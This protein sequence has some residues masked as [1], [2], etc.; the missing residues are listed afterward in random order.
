MGRPRTPT[1]IL[2]LRGSFKK[3]PQRRRTNEP[4][5]DRQIRR[6]SSRLDTEKRAYDAILKAAIPGVLVQADSPSVW[7]ATKLIVKV[8]SGD[9]TTAD[10][11]QLIRLLTAFGLTPS[12]R[13]NL[14]VPQPEKPNPFAE[15]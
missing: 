13:A 2:N 8:D 4:Q 15:D 6:I 1:N 3:N 5:D 12:S 9:F 10:V 14:A 7:L 11:S